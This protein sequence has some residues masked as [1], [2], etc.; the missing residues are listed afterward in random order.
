MHS[1]QHSTS[2]KDFQAGWAPFQAWFHPIQPHLVSSHMHAHQYL[3]ECS[4]G[5]SAAPRHP[6]LCEASLCW[7]S[8]WELSPSSG[9][10]WVPILF[11]C[12]LETQ[13]CELEQP[14]ALFINLSCLRGH[15]ASLPDAQCNES[16]CPILFL[17]QGL[18][19]GGVNLVPVIVSLLEAEV[20]Q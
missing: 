8:S 2:Y 7:P 17:I 4:R 13:A 18:F 3:A 19:H 10:A 11:C 6:Y 9:S 14:R 20:F 5:P 12:G 16:H 1:T 15:C